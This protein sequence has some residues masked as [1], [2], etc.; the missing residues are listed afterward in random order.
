MQNTYRIYIQGLD[1]SI[2]ALITK[3]KKNGKIAVPYH[4]YP[5]KFG[6]RKT[7]QLKK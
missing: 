2:T 4:A 1:M 7:E 6:K 3:G 5:G